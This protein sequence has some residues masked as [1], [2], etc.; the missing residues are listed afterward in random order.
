MTY[1]L[2][3]NSEFID[4]SNWEFTNCYFSNNKLI[5]T[6]KVFGI[7]QTIILPDI[8]KLYFR[9]NY[10]IYDSDVQKVYAGIENSGKLSVSNKQGRKNRKQL[11]SLVEQCEQ[12]KVTVHIIFESNSK[13]NI[14]KISDPLLFDLNR[15][16]K[17]TWLKL[18][19]DKT[20]KYRFGN[21]YKNELEYSEIKPEVFN[22]EKARIGSIIST[23]DK[24]QLKIPAKLIRGKR[25]LIKLDY[26]EI[27]NLGKIYFSYGVLRSKQ[28]N[29]EQ[30]YIVIKANDNLDLQLNIEGNDI[31]PYQV[32]LKHMLLIEMD[33]LSIEEKDI[34]YLPFI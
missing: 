7:K 16:H 2:L 29:K 11:I 32:N 31:L 6:D 30:I 21:N 18:I 28:F 12:E 34:P 14:V 17:S 15:W 3:F 23:K 33:K 22:L 27:N 9:Y 20:I 24:Q 13:E 19:L 4:S 8:T 25:Y 10:N 1:N 26:E 5:S